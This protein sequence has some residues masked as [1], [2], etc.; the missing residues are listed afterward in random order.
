MQKTFNTKDEFSHFIN[1]EKEWMFNRIYESIEYAWH[2]QDSMAEIMEAFIKKAK[3]K[4]GKTGLKIT[5][6]SPNDEWVHSLGLCITYFEEHDEFEKCSD[7]ML[8]RN[9]IK[10]Y[11]EQ[12][13]NNK[14][15]TETDG[16]EQEDV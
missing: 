6:N 13:Y 16:C 4:D 7:I 3:S 12:L 2:M 15:N 11:Q 9:E 5:L 10:T 1:T 14:E 8:L